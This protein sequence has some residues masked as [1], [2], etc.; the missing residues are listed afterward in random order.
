MILIHGDMVDPVALM[1]FL[2]A[3][4]GTCDPLSL[5]PTKVYRVAQ[6]SDYAIIAYASTLPSWTEGLS[7]EALRLTS[8]AKPVSE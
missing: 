1:E 8:Q 2:L 5:L 6:L 7:L 3:E 4:A